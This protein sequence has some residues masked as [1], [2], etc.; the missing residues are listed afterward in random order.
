MTTGCTG[1]HAFTIFQKDRDGAPL[2]FAPHSHPLNVF[3]PHAPRQ[4]QNGISHSNAC[5]FFLLHFS[6]FYGISGS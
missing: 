4:F 5:R 2:L 1:G 6:G 3:S